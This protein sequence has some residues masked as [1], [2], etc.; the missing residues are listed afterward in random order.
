LAGIILGNTPRALRGREWPAADEE[1]KSLLEGLA[2]D[3][4]LEIKL[5]G[6]HMEIQLSNYV[7]SMPSESIGSWIGMPA[8]RLE[9][10]NLKLA[11]CWTDGFMSNTSHSSATCKLH[12]PRHEAKATRDNQLGGCATVCQPK[13]KKE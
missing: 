5:A 9:S 1:A 2:N 6:N 12:G 4:H 3:I 8:R 7:M 13:T 10:K 11:Y